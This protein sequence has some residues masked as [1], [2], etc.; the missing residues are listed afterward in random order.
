[1][2]SVTSTLT[3]RAFTSVSRLNACS[4]AAST[5][6]GLAGGRTMMKF[7]TPATPRTWL[8]IRSTSRFW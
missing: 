3:C 2:W 5:A 8:A 1:M 6:S 4:I 7:C